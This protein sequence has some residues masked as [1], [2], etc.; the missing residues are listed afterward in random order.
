MNSDD[1]VAGVPLHSGA[2]AAIAVRGVSKTYGKVRALH[3]VDLTLRPGTVHALVGEN[4]SGKST[5]TKIIAGVVTPDRGTIVIAGETI[6]HIDPR[7]SIGHGIRVIFQDLALFPNMTVA[8]NLVFEGGAPLLRRVSRRG[9]R[10]RAQ[11]ALE[12]L[13]LGINPSMLLGSLSTAERQ[14]VAIARTVSSD[15]RIILMDEP[16]AALTHDEIEQLLST[17]RGLSKKGLSF[18]FI[19]HKLREVVSIADDV[20]VIRDGQIV[21]SGPSAEYDQE[22]IASLMTGGLVENVRRPTPVDSIE[23]PVLE[24]H[25]LTLASSFHNIDLTLHKGRVVGLAGLVGSG[26]IEVGLAIAGLVQPESGEIRFHGKVMSNV[27]ANPGLQYVPDDRL[28]EGLFLDWPIADNIITNSLDD[29]VGSRRTLSSAKVIEIAD[30]WRTRLSIKTPSV[31]NPVLS[32]SGGN[33]QRVLLARALAPR[34]DVVIL[35]NP[36]VG[37]DIGSRADIHGLIR[38][39]ASD[40]TSILLISD[41]PAELLSVC[42]DV[43][44]MHRGRVV[45]RR[46]ADSLDEDA[47]LDIISSGGQR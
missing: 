2:P 14:L 12:A 41:E 40:G 1:A 4:G 19:S 45:D 21:S 13:E 8:E 38:E 36:T 43:V 39:V 31:A 42:D 44:F 3:N 7:T 5:L 34:P 29:A 18:I 37:V 9:L 35:N 33:Q 24:V 16:T 23:T 20:T 25:D 6:G 27:R 47:L 46:R 17:I 32:L 26:R 22:R 30:Q 15:G 28:T 10:A 11:H